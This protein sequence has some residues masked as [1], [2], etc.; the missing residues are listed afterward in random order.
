MFFALFSLA[1]VVVAALAVLLGVLTA[2]RLVWQRSLA[3]IIT[4]V[5][6][7][8]LSAGAAII[9]CW[10]VLKLAVDSLVKG[11]L[12]GELSDLLTEV[13][14]AEVAALALVSM[15]VAPLLFLLFFAI[16]RPVTGIFGKMITRLLTK[17][18]KPQDEQ[19][20]KQEFKM[21]KSH[22]LSALL[23]GVSGLLLL[24][25]LL[26][27]LV[28]FCGIVED[29][30][31]AVL[32]SVDGDDETMTMISDVTH[33][34]G[35]NAGTVTVKLMG[36]GLLYDLL[37]SYPTE[38]GFI[39]LRH[40]TEFA[41]SAVNGIIAMGNDE[42]SK[43]D[44]T[45]AL[46][47]ISDSFDD[48]TLMP[49]LL[50]ELVG[51]AAEDWNNGNDFHGIECPLSD[52]EFG[53][54][55]LSVTKG[56]AGSDEDTIKEDVRTIVD[57]FCSFIENDAMTNMGDD[58]LSLLS[59]E[60][61]TADVLLALLENPRLYVMVDGISDFGI[62]MLM[63]GL[64]VLSDK[65]GLYNSFVSEIGMVA[66]SDAQSLKSAYSEIFDKYGLA[67][68]DEKLSELADTH[69]AGGD[70]LAWVSTN[71]VSSDEDFRTKTVLIS[72][73]MITTGTPT[74]R[75]NETEARALAHAYAVMYSL[76]GDMDADELDTKSVIADMGPALDSFAVT[77]TIGADGTKYILTAMLQS[78][79]MRDS[80]GFSVLEATD[81]ALSISKNAATKK[82]DGM[83]NSLA[84]LVDVIEAANDADKDTDKAVSVLLDDLSPESADVI[85]TIT[86]PSIVMN[87][88]V[89]EKS[90]VPVSNLVSDTFG[91]LA[92]AKE[93]GMSDE[94]YDKESKA[95]SNMMNVMMAAGS[96]EN[97]GKPM[98]GENSATGKTSK[99]YIDD[100]MDSSVMSGTMVDHVYG[101]G[102]TAEDDPLNSERVASDAEKA[103]FLA[104]TNERW[105]SETD[106]GAD[107]QKK[108]VSA[109]AMININ[110][111]LDTQSNTWVLA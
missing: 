7:A 81:S 102:N 87:Y 101:T 71:V 1:F 58:P 29:V 9:V 18:K 11:G 41:G 106:K 75:S 52:T 24:C 63:D 16:F 80:L 8:L 110:I 88:G 98:F 45:K 67:V 105:N 55:M 38:Y 68:S 97:K 49:A 91:N 84:L 109:G 31:P 34:V 40:E 53:P 21:E 56:L 108:L 14:S 36:G 64:S 22:W 78:D 99:Q 10:V 4:T 28:G 27:P 82:Y 85:K 51:A 92:D 76:S 26:V 47:E 62:N 103:D 65:D 13:P 90:S 44:K 69:A 35:T 100:I 43:E 20:K 79:T 60:D 6:A 3:R 54:V 50:S 70:A 19:E 72:S 73:D 2:R 39:T 93:N 12:L 94:E 95:V 107:T 57:V 96:D 23:G 25:V 86:K 89:S 59:N 77:D 48:S 42:L 83:L 17:T 37:T 15:I 46:T 66:P 33:A 111:K 32:E 104:S 30:V 5:A 74:I 61:C